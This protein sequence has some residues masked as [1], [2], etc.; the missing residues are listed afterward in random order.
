M[1]VAMLYPEPERGGRARRR[2]LIMR[3]RDGTVGASM[4]GRIGF[5]ISARS[6]LCF[7]AAASKSACCS[8][9][10]RPAASPRSTRSGDARLAS[11][12]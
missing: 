5:S 8:R 9:S 6:C 11:A 2:A 4:L 12:C 7:S 3:P 1:A 10:C